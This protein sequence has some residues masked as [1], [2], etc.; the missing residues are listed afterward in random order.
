[1][2]HALVNK[3]SRRYCR[4]EFTDPLHYMVA[5]LLLSCDG[6]HTATV[7]HSLAV[8][9]L[10]APESTEAAFKPPIFGP[11]LAYYVEHQRPTCLFE[12]GT[13]YLELRPLS[14]AHVSLLTL[15]C[16]SPREDDLAFRP[17]SQ[18]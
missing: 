18:D 7:G 13:L 8:A 17:L 6:G 3:R 14:R 5:T 10:R 1:M 9:A 11:F 12:A 4:P 16:S 2:L 15:N